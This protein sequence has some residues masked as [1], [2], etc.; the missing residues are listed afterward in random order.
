MVGSNDEIGYKLSCSTCM[1][2]SKSLTG[3]C[4]L[5]SFSYFSQIKGAQVCASMRG[6]FYSILI[7][8]SKQ[9]LMIEAWFMCRGEAVQSELLTMC[10]KSDR[11]LNMVTE[12]A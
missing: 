9:I 8:Q 3:C 1:L 6:N 4:F 10:N 12:H 2:S 7:D 5:K 11:H